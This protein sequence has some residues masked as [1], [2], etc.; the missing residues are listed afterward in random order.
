MNAAGPAARTDNTMRIRTGLIGSL[1]ALLVAVAGEAATRSARMNVTVTVV[2]NCRIAVTDLAFGEYDPL[3][4]HASQGLDGTAL[5]RV[6]CTRNE[7]ATILMEENGSP[8][9]VLTDGNHR[10]S[11]GIFADPARTQAWGI[12]GNAVQVNFDDGSIPRELTVYGRIPAGQV[13]PAGP[14]SD[15]VTAT[16][17][18]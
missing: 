8:V 2:P 16:V 9:R 17:D 15:A 5:V 3:V 1:L 10:I 7:R 13:V 6:V 18:F 4:V 11:Y 12:A 14:Y